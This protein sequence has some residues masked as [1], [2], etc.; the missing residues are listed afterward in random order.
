MELDRVESK[1]FRPLGERARTPPTSCGSSAAERARG[2]RSP[3]ACGTADGATHSQPPSSGASCPPPSHGRRL[4]ALRPA[5]A[6]WMPRG[7]GECR[8]TMSSTPRRA[9]S[10]ASLQRPRQ[11]GVIRPAGSTAV[12]SRIRSPA[13]P[14]ARWPRWIR[15]QSLASPS[16]AEYWHIGETTIRFASV[17]PRR[18]I[19]SKS[20]L[21]TGSPSELVVDSGLHRIALEVEQGRSE[22]PQLFDSD[23]VGAAADRLDADVVGAGLEVPEDA[24]ADPPRRPT[25]PARRRARCC[26]RRRDRPRRSRATGGC[27]CSSAA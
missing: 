21:V 22:P 24:F 3:S 8:R 9:A 13:P 17:S 23:A 2:A 18:R 26:R 14:R 5:W 6:S 11:S 20:A 27:R 1:T 15:C 12:A 25:R 19:G 16:T 4:D 7:M 10:L